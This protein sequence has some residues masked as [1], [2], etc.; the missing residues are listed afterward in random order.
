M[1]IFSKAIDIL[2]G[3]ASGDA[4]EHV[5]EGEAKEL[6]VPTATQKGYIWERNGLLYGLQAAEF[7]RTTEL[8]IPPSPQNPT[9][10]PNQT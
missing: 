9:N 6:R 7:S 2:G 3:K 1:F 8:L 5:V 4:D 10:L